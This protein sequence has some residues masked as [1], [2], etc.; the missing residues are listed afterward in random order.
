M[1]RS[2]RWPFSKSVYLLR[3]KSPEHVIKITALWYWI[4]FLSRQRVNYSRRSCSRIHCQRHSAGVQWGNCSHGDDRRGS[5]SKSSL[6]NFASCFETYH[7]CDIRSDLRPAQRTDSRRLDR[8][9][10]ESG[11]RYSTLCDLW[12]RT[13]GLS[14]SHLQS[15]PPDRTTTGEIRNNR[16]ST[17]FTYWTQ[18]VS[19]PGEGNCLLAKFYLWPPRES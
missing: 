7:R 1:I 3:Q 13:I 9:D 16:P 14:R 10:E 15:T 12:R 2:L 19:T 11:R 17:F 18:R 6:N 8:V 4:A 5:G